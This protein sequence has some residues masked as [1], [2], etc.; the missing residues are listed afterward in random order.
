[1]DPPNPVAGRGI[2]RLAEVLPLEEQPQLGLLQLLDTASNTNSLLNGWAWRAIGRHKEMVES[3]DELAVVALL[4]ALRCRDIERPLQE[5]LGIFYGMPSPPVGPDNSN[6][7][8][9][10]Q[11]EKAETLAELAMCYHRLGRYTASI[12]AF[13]AAIEAAGEHVASSVLCSCARG[14]SLLLACYAI[15]LFCA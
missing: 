7:T 13:Y 3:Q 4:K 8:G 11:N 5:T 9:L 10:G 14:T 2:L 15:V 12:R 1:M 6:I